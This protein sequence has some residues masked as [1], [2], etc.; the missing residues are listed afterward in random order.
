MDTKDKRVKTA[1]VM[2]RMALEERAQLRE[3]ARDVDMTGSR[4]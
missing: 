1:M 4:S 2:V 3:R